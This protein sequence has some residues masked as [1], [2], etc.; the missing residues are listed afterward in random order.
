MK[1]RIAVLL[2]A[3][4]AALAGCAGR[5]PDPTQA[6]VNRAVPV[7]LRYMPLTI[8][9]GPFGEPTDCTDGQIDGVPVRSCKVCNTHMQLMERKGPFGFERWIE[10]AQVRRVNL[11]VPFKRAISYDQPDI[12][13]EDGASGVWV[14][15]MPPATAL[16]PPPAPRF[17]VVGGRAL[18]PDDPLPF[19]LVMSQNERGISFAVRRERYTGIFPNSQKLLEWLATPEMLDLY[20]RIIGTCDGLLPEGGKP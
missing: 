19:D 5:V 11:H 8:W 2:G 3:C 16:A 9:F 10:S 1:V 12:A 17:E 18:S 4:V 6:D 20:V 7:M 14:L 13:P 15:A